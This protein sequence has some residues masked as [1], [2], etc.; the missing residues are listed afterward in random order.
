MWSL[1]ATLIEALVGVQ[2]FEREW[3]PAYDDFRNT[4]G[5]SQQA[6]RHRVRLLASANTPVPAH[7]AE[8]PPTAEP[9]KRRRKQQTVGPSDTT[10]AP[11]PL[12]WPL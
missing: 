4:D 8:P 2:S 3:M 12:C 7:A 10:A 11:P 6:R 9:A 5:L 1:G